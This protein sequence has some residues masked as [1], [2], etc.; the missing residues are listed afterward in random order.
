VSGLNSYA[1]IVAHY[2]ANYQR[3]AA[4]ELEFFAS[5]PDLAT[6][7]RLAAY[8]T[9][10]AGKRHSH[11]TRRPLST[12]RRAHVELARCDLAACR[13]FDDLL[14]MV[15]ESIRNIDGIGELFVYDTALSIGAFLRLEPDRIYL[16][17]GTRVGALALGFARGRQTVDV[18][19]LPPEFRRLPSH[20]I[21]DCLCIYKRDLQRLSAV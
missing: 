11:H 3:Q 4:H 12:L 9:T 21:E 2:E 19:E 20:E 13:T 5:Q 6:A 15:D 8:A 10:S 7:L 14:R 16:H 17:A 18:D 1:A